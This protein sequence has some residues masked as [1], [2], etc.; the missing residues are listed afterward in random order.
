MCCNPQGHK[1]VDTTQ[2]LN[3]NNARHRRGG[4]GKDICIYLLLNILNIYYIVIHIII[5]YYI[6]CIN[7]LYVL[8]VL[9][10]INIYYIV[11]YYH[12]IVIY[13]HQIV[14]K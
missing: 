14:A 11:I 6:M 9:I 13:Y 12:H 8:Y 1:E 7:I 10:Y 2:K 3:N 4:V 5:C